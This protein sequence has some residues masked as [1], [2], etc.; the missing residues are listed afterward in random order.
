MQ[1]AVKSLAWWNF[2]KSH[3]GLS[4]GQNRSHFEPKPI[5]PP[6]PNKCD[7]EIDPSELDFTNSVCVGKGSFGEIL[8]AHWHGTLVAV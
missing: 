7:W 1:K 3:G 8:K 5:A 6:L 4:F 2:L